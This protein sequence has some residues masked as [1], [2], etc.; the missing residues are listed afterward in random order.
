MT[1]LVDIL[2]IIDPRNFELLWVLATSIDNVNLYNI[3]KFT[4]GHMVGT[5]TNRPK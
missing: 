4:T 1:I 3:Q 2:K 5:S